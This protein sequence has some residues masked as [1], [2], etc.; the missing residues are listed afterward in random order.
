MKKG[1]TTYIALA[2][3]LASCASK[4]GDMTRVVGRFSHDA[5]ESV[6][7]SISLLANKDIL[8]TTVIVDNGRFEVEI[9]KYL[10]SGAILQTGSSQVGF[11]SDGS[12]ITID[13]EAGT[14]VSSNKKGPHTNYVAYL[15]WM[16]N[17]E[18]EFRSKMAEFSGDEEAAEACSKE[19]NRAF[20]EFQRKAAKANPDNVV[21]LQ[22]V[23]QHQLYSDDYSETIALFDGL[24]DEI[25]AIPGLDSMRAQLV[26]MAE[27]T[28]RTAEGKPFVDFTV[29]QDPDHPES[30]TVR[31]SDYIGRGKYV[32]VD[33]WA[34]WC[35]PCKAEMP[36][37]VKVYNTYHGDRFDM[38]SIA[39]LDKV[40][41]STEAASSLGIVWNQIVNAQ[42]IPTTL[43]GIDGIPHIILFGPD[44]TILKRNLRGEKIEETVK[45]ALG[46]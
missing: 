45:E 19:M 27:S 32:L 3:L 9:P 21:G 8:D 5:P 25:K 17:Y 41:D 26:S 43:Y 16:E 38:L 18:S 10:L 31:F 42:E 46:L 15:D 39:V 36:Y 2:L 40:E 24:S 6:E 29:I 37:L 13:P 28:P 1:L 34:S 7:I 12:T 35:G 44:G 23:I 11:L 22:A 14:A 33:F 30:S 4:S 20:I